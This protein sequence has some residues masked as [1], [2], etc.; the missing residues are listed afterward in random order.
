[1][2]VDRNINRSYEMMRS[3]YEN[4]CTQGGGGVT[5]AWNHYV[6]KSSIK[7]DEIGGT[8]STHHDGEKYI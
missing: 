7:T 2:H 8:C 6:M 5:R 1:M 3:I 4:I